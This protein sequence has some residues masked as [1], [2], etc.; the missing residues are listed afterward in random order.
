MTLSQVEFASITP[1]LQKFLTVYNFKAV[2][3]AVK[4]C[5][6]SK[7]PKHFSKL[8]TQRKPSSPLGV[9]ALNMA[10]VTTA[11][12]SETHA[13]HSQ[14]DSLIHAKVE[15]VPSQEA[16]EVKKEIIDISDEIVQVKKEKVQVK[17]EQMPVP[18]KREPERSIANE[19][20]VKQKRVETNN[21][22][23]EED[24]TSLNQK[25]PDALNQ[26]GSASNELWE[27]IETNAAMQVRRKRPLNECPQVEPRKKRRT[28]TKIEPVDYSS[29]DEEV[30]TLEPIVHLEL[31]QDSAQQSSKTVH[32]VQADE[33]KVIVNITVKKDLQ[34]LGMELFAQAQDWKCSNKYK[35]HRFG[36]TKIGSFSFL[37]F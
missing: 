12:S 28:Q 35:L 7:M 25:K 33:E 14:R 10:R 15:T 21:N 37:Y 1:F 6:L 36:T 4:S 11:K 31:L 18:C 26:L 22:S 20:R 17:E 24:C 5:N 3:A 27:F 32:Q 23:D 9:C 19:G 29:S 16:A 34:L 2:S 13:H 30:V 8:N